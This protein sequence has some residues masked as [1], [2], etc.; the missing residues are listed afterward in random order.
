MIAGLLAVLPAL[1][2]GYL[3]YVKQP[4]Q[5]RLVIHLFLAGAIS[6]A[7]LLAYK[8]LWQYFPWINAFLYTDSFANDFVGFANVTLLPLDVLITFMIVGIIEEIAKF[9]AVRLIHKKT[10]CSVTDVMEYFIIVALGFAFIENIIYFYNIMSIRGTENIFL[11][12]IFRSLFS[13]FAHLMFS[14][15]LGY[16]YGQSLLAKPLLK[17]NYN[18]KRW[19]L[20]RTIAKTLKINKEQLFGEEK[21]IQGLLAAI[22]LHAL[23]N[24]FLE[25]NWTFLIIP[26]LGCGFII[27]N[28]LFDNRQVDKDYCLIETT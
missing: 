9:Q 5:K 25:M 17:E 7:P 1:F 24:I 13:T 19:L 11:P 6:V 28:N 21:L 27:L 10:I 26:F 20:T 16:Y 8:Y 3:F 14:G 22:G 23:F 15:I 12:F 18:Q 4:H 2:W